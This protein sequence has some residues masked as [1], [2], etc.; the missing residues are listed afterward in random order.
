MVTAVLK[1]LVVTVRIKLLLLY[2]LVII[3]NDPAR[4]L[5]YAWV[6]KIQEVLLN[7]FWYT[8][9]EVPFMTM[10]LEYTIQTLVAETAKAD[11]F[12]HI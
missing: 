9:D 5:Q 10:P 6:L 2:D 8:K 12:L 1:N 3:F 7:M 4:I 11:P